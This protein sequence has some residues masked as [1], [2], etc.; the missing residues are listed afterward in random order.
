MR[1]SWNRCRK[2]EINQ[3]SG[4]TPPLR[5]SRPV[6]CPVCDFYSGVGALDDGT[7]MSGWFRKTSPISG[8]RSR[9]TERLLLGTPKLPVDYWVT[10]SEIIHET[11]LVLTGNY[12][13]EYNIGE[14]FVGGIHETLYWILLL[15][16]LLSVPEERTETKGEGT[17]V[18]LDEK[19]VPLL[20]SW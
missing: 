13:P 2:K 6:S 8:T 1:W 17:L 3:E 20:I 10:R 5:P 12:S 16:P 11:T 18:L 15:L 9:K 14:E 4:E 19:G 7:R